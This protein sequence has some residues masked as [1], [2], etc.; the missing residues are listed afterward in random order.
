V[1]PAEILALPGLDRAGYQRMLDWIAAGGKHGSLGGLVPNEAV[2]RTADTPW[3]ENLAYDAQG[4]VISMYRP[5]RAGEASPY[6][7]GTGPSAP[8]YNAAAS[9]AAFVPDEYKQGG[10]G[11]QGKFASMPGLFNFASGAAPAQA[12]N[13]MAQLFAAIGRGGPQ[14]QAP[15]VAQKRVAPARL[16]LNK[17]GSR[18]NQLSPK[19]LAY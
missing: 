5:A 9:A 12:Q 15:Q 2:A 1:L 6:G 4:N 13:P 19:Q 7:T 10:A 17:I 11:S 14:A 18:P 16:G 3:G 8:E